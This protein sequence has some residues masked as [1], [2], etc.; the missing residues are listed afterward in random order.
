MDHGFW[1]QA[2]EDGRTNFH[3]EEANPTL[4]AH[5]SAVFPR[6]ARVLVPLCGATHDLR[7]LASNG[8]SAVGVELSPLACA[9]LAER[10][11]LA[12]VAPLG[13]F[14][15]WEAPG[16]TLLCGDVFALT[17]ALVGPI[18]GVWDRAA[19]VALHPDQRAGYVGVLRALLGSGSLLLDVLAY[20][21]AVME[22]PPWSVNADA[23]ADLWPEAVLLEEVPQ[24]APPRFQERGLGALIGRVYRA[25]MG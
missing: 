3:K 6:G 18:D 19:L 2:W 11:G 8:W 20:D 23:V 25:S 14:E 15:R 4:V 16:I 13:P 21:Q 17:P 22:G 7:W 1:L 10:D 9:R 24:D 5:A 12:S